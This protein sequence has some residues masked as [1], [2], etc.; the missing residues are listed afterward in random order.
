L[1][2]YYGK[3]N[4]LGYHIVNF[5]IHYATAVSLFFLILNLLRLPVLKENHVKSAWPTAALATLL[6]ASHPIQVNAVT[7]IVQRMAALAGLFTVLALY[8][9]LKARL[10][11]LA[12]IAGTGRDKH[13]WY[14][15]AL[16]AG[17]AAIGCKENA[18][19]LPFSL[20]LLESTL[21]QP[22]G[23]RGYTRRLVWIGVPATLILLLLVICLGGLDAALGGYSNRPFSLAERLLTQPRILF[24]YIGQLLHPSGAP[25][26]LLHDIE[27]ST[28]LFTP[29]TTLPAIGLLGAGIVL[30]FTGSRKWPLLSFSYLFFLLNHAIEGSVLPLELMFEHR[31]YLPALFFFLPIAMG[32]SWS[33]HYFSYRPLL[34]GML[35]IGAGVWLAGQAH[36]THALNTLFQHPVAFWTNN[37]ELYPRLHR[38]RHNLGKALLI[39]GNTADGETQLSKSL[40]GKSSGQTAHKFITHYNLGVYYL[41]QGVYPQA[42]KQFSTILNASPAHVK[43][44]QKV[45]EVYLELGNGKKALHFIDL[46]LSYAPRRPSLHVVKGFIFLSMGD[47]PAAYTAAD[48]AAG[49]AAGKMGAAYIR[50]E[51]HRLARE[52][53]QAIEFFKEVAGMDT[54]HLPALLSLA[55]LYYLMGDTTKLS[56]VLGRWR[57]TTA[58]EEAGVVLSGYD[59]RWNYVGRERMENLLKILSKI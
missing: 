6:W 55:E 56:E 33:V 43:S 59:R 28:S 45:A 51:G 32:F 13:G 35:L 31:N 38:P 12:A 23:E 21:I 19:M 49:S 14:A 52:Y 17:L 18:A 22:A 34:R 26:T 58:S 54:Q 10:A 24:F 36:T 44:L 15:A 7:Y 57:Q 42:L 30:L 16:L 9:Y 8:C 37:V 11:H 20:L 3:T 40:A 41:Y 1:N 50:G 47:I 4:P 46:A 25:F 5:A 53:V 27:V 29:W 2:Y 48:Q 39:Y